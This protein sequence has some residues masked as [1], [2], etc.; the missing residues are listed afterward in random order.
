MLG[1]SVVVNHKIIDNSN[2]SINRRV[3]AWLV[4]MCHD[5]LYTLVIGGIVYFLFTRKAWVLLALNLI[6]T[7]SIALFLFLKMCVLTLW[8]NSLLGLPKYTLYTYAPAGLFEKDAVVDSTGGKNY[9]LWTRSYLCLVAVLL[10][11]NSLL[12]A[13]TI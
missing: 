13:K 3:A 5:A 6:I 8:F 12:V 10:L 11:L 1:A 9:M 2:V 4:V 7:T